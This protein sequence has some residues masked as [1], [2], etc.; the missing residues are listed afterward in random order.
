MPVHGAAHKFG[1]I[2][3]A[4]NRL[5]SFACEHDMLMPYAQRYQLRLNLSGREMLLLLL[6]QNDNR[7]IKLSAADSLFAYADK[8]SYLALSSV[9]WAV[10]K[11]LIKNSKVNS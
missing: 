7:V 5:L 11:G 2:Y 1:D 10:A 4:V 3:D 9:N 8:P 6:R